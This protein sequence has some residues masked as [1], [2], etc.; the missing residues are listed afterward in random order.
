MSD[1]VE[2]QVDGHGTLT[3]EVDSLLLEACE[4]AGLPIDA[5]CGGFACCNT[6]RVEV[7]EGADRLSERLSEE[8]PFLDTPTQRL[9]C[10]ATVRGPVRVR[11]APGT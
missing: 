9:A 5:A 3:A 2:I 11:L 10:Q 4:A 8:E 1:T 7:L 6:C